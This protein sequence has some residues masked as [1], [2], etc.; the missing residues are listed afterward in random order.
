MPLIVKLILLGLVLI[1]V[2][3]LFYILVSLFNGGESFESNFYENEPFIKTNLDYRLKIDNE[4]PD[5]NEKPLYI[6]VY[7]WV[8]RHGGQKSNRR[9]VYTSYQPL[10]FNLKSNGEYKMCLSDRLL[11]FYDEPFAGKS[12][13][14]YFEAAQTI[15]NNYLQEHNYY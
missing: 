6:S 3:F 4:E 9:I 1:I 13:K 11:R 15:M 8:G 12:G 2:P 14:Y 10:R 5:P 7:V